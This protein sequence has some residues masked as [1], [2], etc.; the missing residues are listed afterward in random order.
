MW[1]WLTAFLVAWIVSAT[2]FAGAARLVE[3]ARTDTDVRR[4]RRMRRRVGLG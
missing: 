1:F 2:V 3:L 4:M